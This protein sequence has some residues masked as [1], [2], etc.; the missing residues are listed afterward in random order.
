MERQFRNQPKNVYLTEVA[1][2]WPLQE[3]EFWKQIGVLRDAA[4]SHTIGGNPLNGGPFLP[5]G[6]I[7]GATYAWE[8]LPRAVVKDSTGELELLVEAYRCGGA[9]CSSGT[10]RGPPALIRVYSSEPARARVFLDGINYK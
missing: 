2:L 3:N 10:S 6:G 9:L 8:N 4:V 5:N 1:H 7:A